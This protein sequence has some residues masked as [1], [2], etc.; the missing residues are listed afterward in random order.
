MKVD[1]LV[2]GA[3]PAG[4]VAAR[5]LA[6]AGLD[7]LLVEASATDEPRPGEALPAAAMPLLRD[8][9]LLERV[10]AGP[11]RRSVGG[12]IAWEGP[13]DTVD[14]LR[15]PHGAGFHL[16]RAAFDATLRQ[17]AL[18]AG[19]QGVRGRVAH[20]RP[21]LGG[22]TVQ[23]DGQSIE[24]RWLVDATGRSAALARALGARR[25]WTDHLIALHARSAP[26]APDVDARTLVE[27]V[28]EGW[29]YLAPQPDGSV[30]AALHV[31]ASQARALRLPA[32][33]ADALQRAPTVAL[34]AAG[35]SWP[36]PPLAWDAGPSHL[37]RP[38]GAGWIAVGDAAQA[39]DP[40][41]AQGIFHALYTGLRGAQS[42]CAGDLQP[43]VEALARIAAAQQR[44]RRA[45]Y[46]AAAR[47]WPTAFW[48]QRAIAEGDGA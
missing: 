39:A 37:D 41:S 32:A 19:A 17:A 25:R 23:V 24:T 30:V 36:A 11:H 46:A 12:V 2:A 34:R 22:F 5:V 45:A 14:A 38:A 29:W 6:Q 44:Q 13:I 4:S 33:W 3:G 28:A 35:R 20:P 8:L 1:A 21:T 7:V 15:D 26:G 16:D 9:G 47:R 31:D 43:Y 42:L 40:L 27:A 10:L 18:E 48:R